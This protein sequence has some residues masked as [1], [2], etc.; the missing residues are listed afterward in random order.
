MRRVRRRGGGRIV[1]AT[2]DGMAENRELWEAFHADPSEANRNRLVEAYLPLLWKHARS[3]CR[4]FPPDAPFEADDLVNYGVFGLMY[5]INSYDPS[6]GI[7]F[8]A[9]SALRIRG[10]MYDGIREV[11]PAGRIARKNLAKIQKLHEREC[12]THEEAAARL[13]I[14]E[15]EYRRARDGHALSHPVSLEFAIPCDDREVCLSERL[16]ASDAMPEDGE[17]RREQLRDLL[18]D[19]SQ[20]ERLLVVSYYHLGQT[21]K[22]IGVAMDRSE[23]RISQMHSRMIE[24][25]RKR[26][27]ANPPAKESFDSQPPNESETMPAPQTRLDQLLNLAP[28]ADDLQLI[29]REIAELESRIDKLKGV[30][31]LLERA[32]KPKEKTAAGG[33]INRIVKHLQANGPAT[34]EAIAADLG[35]E[36]CKVKFS[37]GKSQKVK[38][39]ND[40]VIRAA[41]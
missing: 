39:G 2:R 6:K 7:P 18:R 26:L 38:V 22:E 23:S 1:Q 36:V 29:E 12:V 11:D 34:V 8:P 24:R 5:A 19:C 10:S 15:E 9:Y 16:I 41:S 25:L 31:K 4:N 33:L 28:E 13:G 17:A 32:L 21:M 35:A 14:P 27:G 37:V 30:K 20:D 40:G 3:V